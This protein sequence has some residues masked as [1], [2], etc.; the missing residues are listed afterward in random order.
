MPKTRKTYI[1]R[2]GHRHLIE[3]D[4]DGTIALADCAKDRPAEQDMSRQPDQGQ[5]RNC[6]IKNS[7]GASESRLNNRDAPQQAL[8]NH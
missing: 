1:D 7:A 3:R 2:H 6:S 5:G 8:S 4:A